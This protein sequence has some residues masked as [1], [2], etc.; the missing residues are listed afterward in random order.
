MYS[1]LFLQI[2]QTKHF[3]NVIIVNSGSNNG[4][5]EVFQRGVRSILEN[6]SYTV[7]YNIA[8]KRYDRLGAALYSL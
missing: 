7:S 5:R 3:T 2:A 4:P 6:L 1:W 8:Q